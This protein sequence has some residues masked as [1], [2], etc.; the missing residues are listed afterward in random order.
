MPAT[1][2][3]MPTLG[4]QV[5]RRVSRI[6]VDTA[7]GHIYTRITS[8]S[9]LQA[10]GQQGTSTYRGVHSFA[11]TFATREIRATLDSMILFLQ[12]RIDEGDTSFYF[13]LPSENDVI[14]TWTGEVSSSGTDSRGQA[15]T[16]S[17]G[18]YL[19]KCLSEIGWVQTTWRLGD[20]TSLNFE[21]DHSV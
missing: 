15:V 11:L 17:T 18:R 19:V 3:F 21:Q 13:Y 16:N 4:V 9:Y 20:F 6:R 12:A 5:T 7:P 2:L 10:D 14:A 1:W 8:P